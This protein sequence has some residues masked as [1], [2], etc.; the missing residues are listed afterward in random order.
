MATKQVVTLVTS[1]NVEIKT[2]LGNVRRSIKI[3]SILE[4]KKEEERVNP[5]VNLDEVNSATLE[6]VLEWG[7]FHKVF[8]LETLCT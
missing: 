3:M 7:S 2:N 5:K 1:D 8:K 6:K 4:E